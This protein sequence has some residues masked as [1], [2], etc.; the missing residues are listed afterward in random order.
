MFCE[1]KVEEGQLMWKARRNEA[2]GDEP[3]KSRDGMLGQQ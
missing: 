1:L 2:A 3:D